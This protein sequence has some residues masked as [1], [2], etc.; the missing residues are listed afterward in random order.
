ML[1]VVEHHN[2]RDDEK[3]QVLESE[4]GA[5]PQRDIYTCIDRQSERHG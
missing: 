2:D 1:K 4:E 5:G 3:E